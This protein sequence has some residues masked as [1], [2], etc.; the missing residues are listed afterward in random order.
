MQFSVKKYEK[1]KKNIE[2]RLC[3]WYIL[4]EVISKYLVNI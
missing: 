1:Y 2:I 4:V 3:M